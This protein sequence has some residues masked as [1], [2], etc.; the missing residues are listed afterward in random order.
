MLGDLHPPLS[1]F[2][3]VLTTLVVLSEVTALITG[4][5]I[6]ARAAHLLLALCIVISVGTYYSGYF[7]AESASRSFSV[8]QTAI[9]QHQAV[10]QGA[11]IA[12]AV[13]VLLSYLRHV[14]VQGRLGFQ[15]AYGLS[16]LASYT[17]V[18]Y[19]GYLGAE[20]VFSHGAGVEIRQITP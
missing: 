15:L 16:L 4:K 10:A 17:L 19:T 11:L 18:L 8:P 2:P 3:F 13:T 5:N 9:S 14:A 12:L 6:Y 7:A 20:L 1:S